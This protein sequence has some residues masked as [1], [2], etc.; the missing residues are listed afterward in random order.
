MA[1]L[2]CLLI[3]ENS[4]LIQCADILIGNGCAIAAIATETASVRDWAV[5][6]QI[7]LIDSNGDMA[8]RLLAF[9]YDWLFSIAN[10]RVIPESAWTRARQGAINFHDGPLPEL[11]GLNTPNWSLIEGRTSHGVTWH[12]ITSGIDEGDVHATQSIEVTPDD[13]ALTL[14]TRCYEAGIAS[15]ARLVQDIKSGALKRE[16]QDLTHRT[17]YGRRR[18]PLAA[19]TLCFD[20][21][22]AELSR[23][24]RGLSFGVGY[25]NP[26]ATPKIKTQHGVFMVKALAVLAQAGRGGPGEVLAVDGSSVVIATADL[27]IQVEATATGAAEPLELSTVVNVG[28]RLPLLGRDEI[29]AL[30]ETLARLAPY[31]ER[32]ARRLAE[33]EDIDIGADAPAGQR[34]YRSAALDLPGDLPSDAR[35]GQLLAFLARYSGKSVFDIA[36][37]S[38]ASLQLCA[39]NEGYF[40][41]SLPLRVQGAQDG[42][43]ADFVQ[44]THLAIAEADRWISYPLDLIDRTPGLAAPLLSVGLMRCVSTQEAKPIDGCALTFSVGDDG[45]RLIYDE[46]RFPSDKAAT[47]IARLAICFESFDPDAPFSSIPLISDIERQHLLHDMNQTERAFEETACIHDLI[48]RQAEAEPSAVAVSFRGQSITYGQLEERSDKIAARLAQHVAGPDTIIGLHLPRGIELVIG[49]YAILKAGAAYLPLDPAFPANRLEQMIEDSAATVVLTTRDIKGKLASG[50]SATLMIEDL[51]D[52]P[53]RESA[54]TRRSN[55]GDLAYVIYT[56]GST[57]RPKGVMIEHRNVLNFFAGMDER[58]PRTAGRQD[59]WLAVTSLSFDISVLEIFWTLSRGFKVVVHSSELDQAKSGS[60]A[61]ETNKSSMDFS[62][63]YWGNDD[64]VGP[65]KYRT[66]LEGAKF[67]DANGFQAVWTPERHFH[68]FGGPYPNPAVTGAA[69]AAVTRNIDIRAGSC[70][71]PLHHP[72]RVAEEWAVVDNMS[73]GRVGLAFASGWMP[74][75]FVLR[76]ENAPPNNK[77]AM[78]RDIDIV[79]R[80]WRGEKVGFDFGKGKVEVL[81][82]PRPMSKELPVWITTAGNPDTYRDAARAGANVLTHLLGQSIDE[83]A[84]KITI[85]R[86]TLVEIGRNP[87]DFKVTVML[88]TLVGQDREKVRDL[89]RGPMKDYLRSAAALIKQYAWAFPAFKKPAGLSNPMDVDLQALSPDEM[90]AILEFAFTRYF[91]DSGLFGTVDD[92][93]SRASQLQRIG[94]DEIACLIDFGLPSQTVLD[95]LQPLSEVVRQMRSSYGGGH[96]FAADIRREG[97]THVQCTPSMAGMFLNDV[98]DRSAMSALKHIFIGGEPLKRALVD[99]LRQVT[100]ATI[101]NMY[102]PTE[103][104]IWSSTTPA[105]SNEDVMPLGAPIANTQFYILDRWRQPTPPGDAGELYIGGAGVARGYLNRE[106]LT[107]ERFMPNPFA[108]GRMYRTGDLVRYRPDGNME[109]LGRVDNQVKIRGNRIELGEI[110]TRL[111]GLPGVREAVITVR[112]DREGDK[113]IVAYLRSQ[114]RYSI[115][116]VREHLAGDLPEYMIPAHVVTLNQFPLT[117]NAKVDRSKLPRPVE[118]EPASIETNEAT[119]FDSLQHTVAEAF[120]RVLGVGRVGLHD[121]FFA[122]GGHSLLAVQMHRDLKASIAPALTITDLF[123]YPTVAGLAGHISGRTESGGQLNKIAERA[124]MRRAAM[125]SRRPAFVRSPNAL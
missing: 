45:D 20:Q 123:R 119:T 65:D 87:A 97:V 90:D 62:L 48:A 35:A 60:D 102:G 51:L 10:L 91:E 42:S 32:L 75:D 57:G 5:E 28:D 6:R 104:T 47:M 26:I 53:I 89:A 86:K 120:K 46:S 94:V 112:E 103:T 108:T 77:A 66:L 22:A 24:F 117:P 23:L 71:L 43:A 16:R 9:N 7:P 55:P 101:E 21:S 124:S 81:T 107:S 52:S 27:P 82:Q 44:A 56:S 15:F 111:G 25:R 64:G 41:R 13:T 49:A 100:A 39:S 3:G 80:L 116:A 38:D 33:L 30:D 40:A 96:G 61:P 122:L 68:A 58:V 17:Y 72:A 109:F 110:E 34:A 29:N 11:A 59:V 121:N 54:Q 79:R 70:V 114:V 113:R 88:H 19:G 84:D 93:A 118:A 67:A 31:E 98:A 37:A 12:S 2:S 36:Y 50:S 78:L 105:T 14:N 125:E 76:P 85:Y 106:D 95:A 83:L 4:L 73:G 8:V 63:F 99:E 74:E 115:D 1:K 69:V 18:R 92:A